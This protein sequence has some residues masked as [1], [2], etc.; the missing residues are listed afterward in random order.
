[1]G[2]HKSK[3][4]NCTSIRFTAETVIYLLSFH[5]VITVSFYFHSNIN[6]RYSLFMHRN[7]HILFVK[8]I[9]TYTAD[10]VFPIKLWIHFHVSSIELTI[11][12][13]L[14]ALKELTEIKV[15]SERERELAFTISW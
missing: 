14:G 6:Q 15:A 10:G 11:V 3:N 13:F 8:M 12:I 2:R 4:A 9:R 5:S 7:D 1:M